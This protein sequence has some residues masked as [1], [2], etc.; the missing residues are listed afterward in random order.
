M[1]SA[2]A[3]YSCGLLTGSA[4][5]EWVWGVSAHGVAATHTKTL[6]VRPAIKTRF[7][8]SVDGPAAALKPQL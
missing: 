1:Q 5:G 8:S 3:E 6:A 7:G 2:H 4:H